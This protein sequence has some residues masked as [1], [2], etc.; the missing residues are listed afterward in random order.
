MFN[1]NCS[2]FLLEVDVNQ[3]IA[4]LGEKLAYGGKML[5]VGMGIVFTVIVSLFICLSIFKYVGQKVTQKVKSSPKVEATPEVQSAPAPTSNNDEEIVAVIAAAIA[6]A[7][8]EMPNK[9]F[10]VVSFKRI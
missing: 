9:K 5:I 6:A 3:P 2:Q 7:S 8:A 4:G 10:R 1:F